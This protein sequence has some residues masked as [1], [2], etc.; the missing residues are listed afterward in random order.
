MYLRKPDV[1]GMIMHNTRLNQSN[2][3][4]F[5]VNTGEGKT[6]HM[7]LSRSLKLADS[8]FGKGNKK[9]EKS[10][11]TALEG[12]TR[13]KAPDD[14]YRKQIRRGHLIA[15]K[16]L[17]AGEYG[18]VYLATQTNVL[19]RGSKKV[20]SKQRAVKLLKA[21][22]DMSAKEE[23][24]RECQ[25]L[26]QCEGTGIVRMLGVAVQQPPWLC[27]LEYLE[28][29]DLR[30]FLKVAKAK[31]VP[32][33]TAEQIRI[34]GQLASGCGFV[35]K[36]RVVH[37]DLAARNVLLGQANEIKIADFGMTRPM[38]K[39]SDKVKFAAPIRVAIKWTAME[40]MMENVFSEASDCW[41]LGI[42]F[43]EICSMGDM[44]CAHVSNRDMLHFL[45]SGGRVTLPLDCPDD[46]WQIMQK[47]W[48]EAPDD[49]WKFVELSK[50]VEGLYDKY[51]VWPS[52]DIG[53]AVASAPTGTV[54]VALSKDDAKYV[55][56]MSSGGGDKDKGQMLYG[57][58][59]V[60][61]G[62]VEQDG[63]D[64]S[65]RAVRDRKGSGG[66]TRQFEH[67]II[68]YCTQTNAGNGES[69][70]KKISEA[71]GNEDIVAFNG[72]MVQSGQNWKEEVGTCGPF[73][74]QLVQLPACR[75][76]LSAI[77]L[78]SIPLISQECSRW[79]DRLPS[80]A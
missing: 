56:D 9:P 41:S 57:A 17:G 76:Q 32:L 72:T 50:A 51:P 10:V 61:R 69:I 71:L 46:L 11:F 36:G 14:L 63:G 19:E 28:Y 29:G 23:F 62:S 52:R 2:C 74:M 15:D 20:I 47:C 43:W 58:M 31:D 33:T 68:S 39:G 80:M 60:R 22:A 38:D 4:L 49:R 30:S 54:E 66:S 24:I 40:A 13:E 7:Q 48:E 79:C 12:Y 6:L 5:W 77:I 65:D 37:M 42:V 53:K 70:M 45:V 1:Y 3:H 73:P 64:L 78:P 75:P 34:C 55:Y 27:V 67:G 25:M 44:P 26:I 18:E 8:E 16:C 35:S 21:G 59:S